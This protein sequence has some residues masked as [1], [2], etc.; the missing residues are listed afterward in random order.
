M[1]EQANATA[2]GP[3]LIAAA[4]RFQPANARIVDDPMAATFLPGSY[5]LAAK[6]LRWGWMRR[7]IQRSTERLGPGLYA[8]F[9]CRKRYL[10]DQL[11]AAIDLPAGQAPEAML[12]LGA[13]YDS[14]GHRLAVP[15]GLRL[16]E[17]DQPANIAHKRTALR[18]HY[19]EHPPGTL[20][21]IDF[22]TQ[23]LAETLRA[24]GFRPRWRCFVV[25]E[26]VTQYL[27]MDGLRGTLAY[28]ETFAPGSRLV[29][30]Y[31][32]RAFVDGADLMGADRLYREVVSK[33]HLFRTGF[34]PDEIQELLRPYRWEV[35][36][37]VGAAEY[38]ER[39]IDPSGRGLPITDGERAVLAEKL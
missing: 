19:G 33:Q 15:A 32:R 25:W 34:E 38:R 1:T 39:Y 24:D 16:F 9:L 11:S 10:D 5:R 29:F 14:R 22:D 31:V 20:V 3:M 35:R 21:P 36:E 4:D 8:S 6:L 23:D 2:Y 26:A 18:R 13:G 17:V 28:L 12:N 37:Q 30:T 7:A 27:T